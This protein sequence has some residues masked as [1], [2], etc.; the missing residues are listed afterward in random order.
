VL[1][2]TNSAFYGLSREVES[3]RQAV[4]IVGMEA[5]KNLV[6]SA[7]VLDM[8]KGSNVDQEFQ[9]KFWRHSLATGSCCRLLS[10]KVK[11]KG[12]LDPDAAFSAG[13]LHDIGKIVINSYL[14]AEAA[15]LQ[16]ARSKNTTQ[17]DYDLENNTIGYNHAQIGGFMA[18]HW[19]LPDKLSNAITCHHTP[20][21]DENT[22]LIVPVVHLSNYV[23]KQTFYDKNDSHLVGTV[24]PAVMEYLDLNEEVL[25][26][27]KELLK[28]DFLKAET[29]MSMAGV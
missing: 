27:L 19:K 25:D 10:K 6:L 18:V 21:L 3:V 20:I 11:A 24:D 17:T 13:L 8:F 26:G 23:A 12:F 14:K 22:D 15:L 28:E 16:S 4:V 9:D 5:I 29:F 2:L 1:K 7:S